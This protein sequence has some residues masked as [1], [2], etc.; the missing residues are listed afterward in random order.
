MR[1][2]SVKVNEVIG[3]AGFIVPGS[4]VDVVATV[5]VGD[6]SITRTVVSNLR[7]AGCGMR[8]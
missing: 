7:G 8:S 4:H 6:C 5:S 2:V 1:A 3:V